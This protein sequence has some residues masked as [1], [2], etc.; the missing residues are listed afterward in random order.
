MHARDGNL[1]IDPLPGRTINFD[2]NT[3][4]ITV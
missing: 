3:G 2:V 1:V 4:S